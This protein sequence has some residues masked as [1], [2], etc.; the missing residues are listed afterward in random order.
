MIKYFIIG[1][2]GLNLV[3]FLMKL[4]LH[5]LNKDIEKEIKNLK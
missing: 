5:Y 2:I 3:L 1:I 4:Y